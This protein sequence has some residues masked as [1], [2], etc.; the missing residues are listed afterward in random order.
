MFATLCYEHSTAFVMNFFDFNYRHPSDFVKTMRKHLY[1][2]GAWETGQSWWNAMT[3]PPY[4]QMLT[5]KGVG[6]TFNMVGAEK[7]L[8]FIK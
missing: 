7:L 2:G 6:W 1:D 5:E 8:N 4:A 3:R